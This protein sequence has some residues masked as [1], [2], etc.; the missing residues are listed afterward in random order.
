MNDLS[1]EEWCAA[2][3]HVWGPHWRIRAALRLSMFD[4]QNELN[5][6]DALFQACVAGRRGGKSDSIPK[7]AIDKVLGAGPNEVVLLG[8]DTLKKARALHWGNLAACATTHGAP[9]KPNQQGAYWETP[10]G[11]RVQFWGINDAMSVEL[12]RGFKVAGAMFDECATYAGLLERMVRD[13]LEPA[14]GDTGGQLT[15]YGTPSYTR[16]GGW[17]D[18]CEGKDA[19]KWKLFRWD[20]RDN[21]HFRAD[22]GG[23]VP[24]FEEVLCRNGW[25]WDTAAFKR[26]YLG[27][28]VDDSSMMV[29]DYVAER[30]VITS[31]PEDYSENWPH[32]VGI[33]FGINDA[34]AVVVL[35]VSPWAPARRYFVHAKKASGLD[36]DQCVAMLKPI[37]ERY[38]PTSIVCDP[39]GGGKPFY[40]T[41]N[42]RH[43]TEL[44][45]NIRS[46]PKVAGSLV[47]SI[48]MQNTEFRTGR[49]KVLLP[50][51]RDLAG[52]WQ[53]LPWVDEFRDA[54][55]DGFAQD[56][57]DAGR[58]ALMDT[59]TMV[60]RER[61]TTDNAGER[62]EAQ[63]RRQ[64]EEKARQQASRVGRF[65]GKW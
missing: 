12:M 32:V 35:A 14:L 44:G 37:A 15:L 38:R 24:Y 49:L 2:A 18:I 57:F 41:F 46:A 23:A 42:N 39:A 3:Q 29:C 47:E 43:G 48:R 21:P 63:L 30:D 6:D 25:T 17:F 52:E 19:S 4:K 10:T 36:I 8:A 53:V 13:V 50:A 51:C 5:D 7:R 28:F 58:Y 27:L 9:L 55:H 64:M 61:P 34:F 54:P 16:A 60:P 1:D 62:L 26:E 22:R 45:V 65:G 31:L 56:L 59:I 11:A 40:V 33:D 20:A